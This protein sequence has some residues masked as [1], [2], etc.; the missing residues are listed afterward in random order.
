MAANWFILL[1][2]LLSLIMIALV[3]VPAE[4]KNLVAQFGDEYRAYQQ[5]TDALLPRLSLK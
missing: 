3:V 2:A 5:R 4:E 1:F